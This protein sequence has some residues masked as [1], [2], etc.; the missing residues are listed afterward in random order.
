MLRERSYL[1]KVS[2]EKFPEQKTD[3]THNPVLLLGF[4]RW[5]RSPL[6][7]FQPLQFITRD[8]PLPTEPRCAK[9]LARNHLPDVSIAQIQYFCYL[10]TR[11]N[12]EFHR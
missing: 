3:G 8:D 1:V 2:W 12:G 10:L 11:K 5:T 7:R 4:C 9:F 6:S